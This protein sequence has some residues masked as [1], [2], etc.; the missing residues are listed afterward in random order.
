MN[1]ISDSMHASVLSPPRMRYLRTLRCW[2]RALWTDSMSASSL[3]AKLAVVRLIQC[4]EHLTNQV[5]S[6]ELL[7]NF[8]GKNQGWR[9]MGITKCFWNAIWFS[10]MSIIWSIASIL[11]KMDHNP[12]YKRQAKSL[13]FEKIRKPEW[14]KL[15]IPRWPPSQLT[16]MRLRPLKPV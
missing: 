7:M 13:R 6:P 4:K 14:S 16:R 3:M 12:S 9:I 5:S 8:T 10:Y 2:S 11:I 15:S 1:R